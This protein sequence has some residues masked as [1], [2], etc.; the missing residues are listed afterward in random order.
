M[1]SYFFAAK[2]EPQNAT[3]HPVISNLSDEWVEVERETE[4]F[5]T[6]F[7]KSLKEI[8]YSKKNSLG[9]SSHEIFKG[10]HKLNNSTH[11]VKHNDNE[12]MIY[13]ESFM[14]H[15]YEM[16]LLYGVGRSY[17]RYNENYQSIASSSRELAGF[18]TFK[19]KPLTKEQLDDP[20]FRERFIRILNAFFIFREDDGHAGNI[21]TN[22][23]IFDADCALW[24][25]T[26]H[27]EPVGTYLIKGGRPNVDGYIRDPAIA[28]NLIDKDGKREGEQDILTFPNLKHVNPWYFASRTNYASS[29][30]TNN[31]WR[32]EEVEL[33]QGLQSEE[34]L[35]I[36]FEQYLDMLLDICIRFP[37]LAALH[38]PGHLKVPNQEQTIVDM[39]CKLITLIYE[40][41][42]EVL[43]HMPSFHHF[44]E[45][46][47]TC[48]LA[49]ILTNCFIRNDRLE[50]EKQ[51][52][53]PSFHEQMEK[54]KITPGSIIQRFN[55]I[56][57]TLNNKVSMT[58]TESVEIKS[59]DTSQDDFLE[60]FSVIPSMETIIKSEALTKIDLISP[61]YARELIKHTSELAM[62][63]R[64]MEEEAGIE[65]WELYAESP[66]ELQNKNRL[67]L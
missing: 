25:G 6:A 11:F 34:A 2:T 32:P 63:I 67:T 60:E 33:V 48:V 51:D 55:R 37:Y 65:E 26:Y 31:P 44:L 27:D 47:S 64:K 35:E 17:P 23:K 14:G 43:T 36:C 39:Y 29:Y 58:F 5:P 45:T 19:D 53:H 30:V 46:K 24:G 12:A 16:L 13:C 20:V 9:N 22:L 42:F 56:V 66:A 57:E 62:E 40:E 41:F 61:E 54:A 8:E 59:I 7:S 28:F 52:V 1:L 10:K 3:A 21:T 38:I 50:K 15:L 4:S 49:R 18:E